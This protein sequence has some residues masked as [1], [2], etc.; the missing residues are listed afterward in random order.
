MYLEK[1]YLNYYLP[2][3]FIILNFNAIN[4]LKNLNVDILLYS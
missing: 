2:K 4:S 1:R 3:L